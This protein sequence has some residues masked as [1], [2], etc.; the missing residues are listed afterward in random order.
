VN[1]VRSSV[2]LGEVKVLLGCKEK[3]ANINQNSLLLQANTS[4]K[5]GFEMYVMRKA[6]FING[7]WSDR[8]LGG[9]VRSSSIQSPKTLLPVMTGLRHFPSYM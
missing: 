2:R 1:D 8:Y 3:D 5:V 7:I 4:R 9:K 6:K